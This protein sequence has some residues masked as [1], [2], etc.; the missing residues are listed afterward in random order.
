M[1]SV[2]NQSHDYLSVLVIVGFAAAVRQTPN[3]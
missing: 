3:D 1:L 2:F